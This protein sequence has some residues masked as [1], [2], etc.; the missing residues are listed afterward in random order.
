M[1]RVLSVNNVIVYWLPPLF[2]MGFIFPFNEALA[3]SNTSSFVVPLLR[4]LLPFSDFE[5]IHQ[6]HIGFRKIGHF[7]EY[8]FLAVLLVRA[9][10]G[11][12]RTWRNEWILYA[13]GVA[14][15]YGALDEF[16]QHFIPSRTGSVFDWLID[17]AGVLFVLSLMLLKNNRSK[18]GVGRIMG[19]G[20]TGLSD[21]D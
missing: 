8:A 10:R 13:G 19:A 15:G 16:L 6:M 20:Q 7:A 14:A 12:K 21:G 2:W 17:S 3:M 1:T 4:W 5:T 11:R 9:F 18:Q